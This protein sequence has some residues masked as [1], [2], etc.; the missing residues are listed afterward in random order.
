MAPGSDFGRLYEAV[1]AKWPVAYQSLDIVGRFGVTHVNTCG[2][3]DGSPVVLLPGGRSTSAGWFANVGALAS[4]HSVYSVDLIGDAGRSV[5]GKVPIRSRDDLVAWLDGLLDGL[6][7][8]A[9]SLVGHS[10]GAWI[11]ASYAVAHPDRVSRLVLVE[12]TDTLSRTR[13]IFRLRA[14]PLVLGGGAD[15][16]RRFRRWETGDG[17]VDPGFLELWAG[18]F[19]Q[20]GAGRFVW[21]K[22]LKSSE[23]DRL[24]M[25]VL[26]FAAENSRQNRATSLAAAAGKLPDAR[27]VLIANATHFTVPQDRPQDINPDLASFLS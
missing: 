6:A 25:P 13:L 18:S 12:P 27:I 20:P 7:L 16:Y 23:L 8:E 22:L 26:V 2:P 9:T 21:P 17:P 11:A 3:V 14:I 15:R 1:L 10:Y 24:T 4:T 19:A 5:P